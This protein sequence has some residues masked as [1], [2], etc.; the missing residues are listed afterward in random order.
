MGGGR[1]HGRAGLH[2]IVPDARKYLDNNALSSVLLWKPRGPVL[3]GCPGCDVRAVSTLH[4]SA[5]FEPGPAFSGGGDVGHHNH[6]QP[7]LGRRGPE[8]H[9]ARDSRGRQH[10]YHQGCPG[11]AD[12]RTRGLDMGGPARQQRRDK[13]GRQLCRSQ[14]YC[15][16]GDPG[17]SGAA[18]RSPEFSKR[19]AAV[20]L[21]RAGPGQLAC[22]Q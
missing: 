20:H 15:L 6:H 10:R 22:R 8:R 17:V 14:L 12:F 9:D 1:A 5:G 3:L 16:F 4:F 21:V 19:A 2:L 7:R 11:A 18:N 13:G